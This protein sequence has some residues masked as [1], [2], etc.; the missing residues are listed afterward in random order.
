MVGSEGLYEAVTT[1]GAVGDFAS[2][3]NVRVFQVS[4]FV[5]WFDVA[6]G[7]GFIIPTPACRMCCCI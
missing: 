3:A 2:E 6:R 1:A 4:G 5:K 7:Y